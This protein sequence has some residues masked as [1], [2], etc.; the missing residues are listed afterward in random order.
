MGEIARAVLEAGGQ[1]TGI[2]PPDLPPHETPLEKIQ[3]LI[4]V[5]SLHERK[6]LMFERS[7]AFV[8]LP[9]GVGTLEELVEQIT[10][11]QLGHHRKPV[12]IANVE[13]Y[14]DPLLALF[15]QMR[16]LG[17]ISSALGLNYLVVDQVEEIIPLL[18]SR[19]DGEKVSPELR[20]SLL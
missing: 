9:G 13:G 18:R 14:W 20:P 16:A 19:P 10:W 5:R 11:V 7:D 2:R 17:F 12:I 15:D 1:V 4:Q 3:E 8:A 6:M